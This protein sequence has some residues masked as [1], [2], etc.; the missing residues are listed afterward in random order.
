MADE[1]KTS[2]IEYKGK[3]I[4]GYNKKDLL[5]IAIELGA[6]PEVAKEEHDKTR[7]TF[8]PY[9]TSLVVQAEA[10]KIDPPTDE[11]PDYNNFTPEE[12]ANEYQRLAAEGQMNDVEI[13]E[14]LQMED[15][16]ADESK[17]GDDFGPE[18]F[19]I[20]DPK[21]YEALEKKISFKA[22]GGDFVFNDAKRNPN[23]TAIRI[24]TNDAEA[25]G[26]RT[27]LGKSKIKCKKGDFLLRDSTGNRLRVTSKVFRAV[28]NKVIG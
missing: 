2:E 12:K 24:L 9:V 28:Y 17:D 27:K 19:Y 6:D 16:P 25:P 23:R 10:E 20:E 18:E 1:E 3:P 21:F 22:N 13:R 7:E 26:R 4:D 14:L 8:V 11:K 5:A 15:A